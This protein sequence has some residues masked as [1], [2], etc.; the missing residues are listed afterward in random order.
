MIDTVQR[1]AAPRSEA[2]PPVRRLA[3]RTRTVALAPAALMLAL[4]L[5]GIG[6]EDTLWGD[7]AVTYEIAHRTVPEIWR[8]LGSID[9]VHGLYYLLMHTVFALWDGGLVALR[10]PS[11]LAMCA[12]AAGVA[13]IG[14]R[15]AGP[16]AGLLAG[17][18]LALLPTVQRYAQEGRSYAL[19]CALVTWGTW[20]L[21]KRWWA[22][23]A[24]VMLFACLLHEFAVLALLA[25][26]VTVLRAESVPVLRTKRVPVLRTEM[27]PWAVA[28]LCV[29][30][31]LAPLAVFSTTQ[32]AQVDWIGA[33][34]VSE[35]AAFAALALLGRACA[36]TPAGAR[37]RAVALPLLV[38]PMG[39]LMAVSYVHP[40]FVDRYVLPYVI[41]LALLL[42]AVLDHYWSRT[43]A[44]SAAAAVLLTLVV[45]GPQLRSPESRKSNVG[46]VALAVQ[47][48][49]RPGDGLLF[50]PSRRRVW[51]LVHPD[52]FRGLTDLSLERS[53]R[54]SGTLF[55]TEAAPD[56]IRARM[57][58]SGRIVV[59]QD[60]VGQPLDAVEPE[61]VK[62]EVLRT[63]FREC[64]SRT[65]GQARITLYVQ[66][67]GRIGG[68]IGAGGCRTP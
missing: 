3:L 48:A 6:R 49:S 21:L 68:R 60:L 65:V 29:A 46:A 54:A 39:L 58:A 32:A 64:G 43:L 23:Y 13:L 33:P 53:P 45:H 57:R 34:G 42:G 20:L 14:R 67:D 44:L 8:T 63:H 41:G 47:E 18:V 4:G 10:L 37:V 56:D 36:R 2:A 16:R 1:L 11:V 51:T 61:V 17:L 55:G 5:W 15:L 19:V 22:A 50:T 12:T 40:L 62:R 27:R 38:L 9:A 66:I 26:G 30:V 59:V 52:A 31:G 25:H 7:E 35:V 28:A 24:V